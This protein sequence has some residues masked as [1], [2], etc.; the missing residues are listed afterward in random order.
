MKFLDELVVGERDVFGHHTFTKDEILTFARQYDPQPFHVDEEAARRSQFGALAASGWHTAAMWMHYFVIYQQR[1]ADE[2]QAAGLKVARVGPS[3]G[4]KE[5]RWLKP[6]YVGDTL[7]YGATVKELVVSR[8]KP[9]WGLLI[10]HNTGT[11]QHGD[12]A[13]DF[14]GR[15]FLQRRG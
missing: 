7:T 9:E 10:S 12:L 4:F 1:I 2:R 5:M 14:E 15:V 8:S 13:F 3:P 11:N 6:V